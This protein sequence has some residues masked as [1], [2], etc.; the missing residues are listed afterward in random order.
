MSDKQAVYSKIENFFSKVANHHYDSVLSSLFGGLHKRIR[1]DIVFE[2][3]RSMDV[4]AIPLGKFKVMS[5]GDIISISDNGDSIFVEDMFNG[6]YLFKRQQG[7]VEMNIDGESFTLTDYN[8]KAE[9][10][11]FITPVDFPQ[12]PKGFLAKIHKILA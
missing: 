9:T 10:I 5:K 12:V 6:K 7:I 3:I 2:E 1:W 11:S 8:D 4:N